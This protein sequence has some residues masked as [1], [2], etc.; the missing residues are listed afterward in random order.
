[1]SRTGD[2]PPHFSTV[3][4]PIVVYLYNSLGYINPYLESL[5]LQVESL[6]SFG[7]NISFYLLPSLWS[8]ESDLH[9]PESS[10]ILAT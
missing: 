2:T 6:L 5:R 8:C 4:D 7:T 3:N 1:M 10:P 9:Q